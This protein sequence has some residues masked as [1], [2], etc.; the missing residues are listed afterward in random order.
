MNFKKGT[1]FFMSF[2]LLL[3]T[4]LV[5]LP[6]KTSA[7][8]EIPVL[9]ESLTIIKE[10]DEKFEYIL[11]IDGNQIRYIEITEVMDDGS[12]VIHTKSYNEETNELLQDF[13]TIN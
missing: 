10:T 13:E 9:D 1:A 8:S 4:V 3:G 2:I 11:S 7:N 12:K 5:V 6:S